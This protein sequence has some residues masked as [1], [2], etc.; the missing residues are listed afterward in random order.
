MSGA[1]FTEVEHIIKRDWKRWSY[2]SFCD[3]VLSI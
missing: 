1:L 3:T 2:V